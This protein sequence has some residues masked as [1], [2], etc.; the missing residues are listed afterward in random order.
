[1]HVHRLCE[2]HD[3]H[4]IFTWQSHAVHLT[5]ISPSRAQHVFT[6]C[7]VSLCT[8]RL[9]SHDCMVETTHTI[10]YSNTVWVSENET[11]NIWV[12]MYCEVFSPSSIFHLMSKEKLT[13][14]LNLWTCSSMYTET[15]YIYNRGYSSPA[16]LTHTDSFFLHMPV[17]RDQT[18]SHTWS[19]LP[20]TYKKCTTVENLNS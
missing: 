13:R 10:P 11:V 18:K 1:M 9:S 20:N 14:L 3:S 19:T 8:Y 2:S 6:T 17:P 15:T 4:M 7:D 16:P 5:A 12:C